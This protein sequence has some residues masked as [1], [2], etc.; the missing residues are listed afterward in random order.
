M[1]GCNS[2]RQALVKK[3]ALTS[4]SVQCMLHRQALA[5]KSLPD[6]IQTVLE[7]MIQIINFIKARALNSRVCK[8]LCIDMDSDHLVLFYHTQTRWLSK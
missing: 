4:K 6:S 8:R 7:E 1:L 2:D 5:F 3:L